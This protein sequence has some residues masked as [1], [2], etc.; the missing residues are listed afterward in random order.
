MTTNAQEARLFSCGPSEERGTVSRPFEQRFCEKEATNDPS[1]IVRSGGGWKFKLESWKSPSNFHD[2]RTRSR[3]RSICVEKPIEELETFWSFG[4][5]EG[6]RDG[7]LVRSTPLRKRS[8]VE[9]IGSRGHAV[10]L[11]GLYVTGAPLSAD[12]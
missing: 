8:S 3:Y 5:L 4:T 9:Y 12:R 11:S 1:G 2:R 6:S 10:S 7:I